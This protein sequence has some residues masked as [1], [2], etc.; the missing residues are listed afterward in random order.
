MWY[1]SQ[2]C[3]SPPGEPS[4]IRG[5]FGILVLGHPLRF[6]GAFERFG[7]AFTYW[8]DQAHHILASYLRTEPERDI[9]LCESR[10]WRLPF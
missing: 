1:S 3:P 5:K 4:H 9:E 6:P 2:Q 7:M 10:M 8:W